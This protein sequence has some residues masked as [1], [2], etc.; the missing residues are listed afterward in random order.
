MKA[1]KVFLI[2]LSALASSLSY[3]AKQDTYKPIYVIC[4]SVSA[5]DVWETTYQ[6]AITR[7][8]TLL[9]SYK[10]MPAGVP[11]EGSD[12]DLY[13]L[14]MT[15]DSRL[16][17]TWYASS[18]LPGDVTKYTVP[19]YT[20]WQANVAANPADIEYVTMH[21]GYRAQAKIYQINFSNPNFDGKFR[22]MRIYIHHV[23]AYVWYDNSVLPLDF[24][25]SKWITNGV[26]AL[27]KPL[28]YDDVF[29]YQT[30]KTAFPY[31]L[32]KLPWT[33]L[34]MNSCLGVDTYE[35][36]S[37]ALPSYYAPY[38]WRDIFWSMPLN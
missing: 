19:T 2:V 17:E 30:N 25:R 34:F 9:A 20:Q 8:Q 1:I 21:A 29:T 22:C 24:V 13:A 27:K 31:V 12:G 36:A 6:K 4:D 7:V 33:A 5:Y 37:A 3:C 10:T 28:S 14:M 15:E 16:Y 26:Y 35:Y 23:K 32:P 18:V 38:D 11:P